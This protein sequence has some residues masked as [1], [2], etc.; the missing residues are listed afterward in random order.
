MEFNLKC[1]AGEHH[2]PHWSQ[3]QHNEEGIRRMER[4]MQLERL[5]GHEF[6]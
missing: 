3:R 2:I 5:T 1:H 4:N 6:L